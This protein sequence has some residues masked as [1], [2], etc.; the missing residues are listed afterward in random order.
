[1]S[2][3]AT[4]GVWVALI[5]LPQIESQ[6]TDS[7]DSLMNPNKNK[8]LVYPFSWQA[9]PT[10]GAKNLPA[11][12]DGGF[13]LR[14]GCNLQVTSEIWK[15]ALLDP[16]VSHRVKSGA[17]EVINCESDD[18]SSPGYR[19]FSE[20]VAL[21]LVRKTEDI[22]SLDAWI[23]GENRN[24]VIDAANKKKALIAAELLKRAA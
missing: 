12:F 6:P 5:Y 15:I 8:G 13:T 2:N 20:K 23:R 11:V 22:D 24:V 18:N 1:M 7:Y 19:H 17:I 9:P 3:V 21:D 4:L 10:M 14:P 16:M